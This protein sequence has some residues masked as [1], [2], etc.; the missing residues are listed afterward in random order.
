MSLFHLLTHA[1][2]LIEK[3]GI[4]VVHFC[5]NRITHNIRYA[6]WY[7]AGYREKLDITHVDLASFLT[8]KNVQ[9]ARSFVEIEMGLNSL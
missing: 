5:M 8:C 6:V 2:P 7:P 4:G 9:D 3:R 1:H